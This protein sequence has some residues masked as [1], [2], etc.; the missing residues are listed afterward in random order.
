MEGGYDALPQI[1]RKKKKT[2][3]VFQVS[4]KIMECSTAW[5]VEMEQF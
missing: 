4:V 3:L 1:E 2:A 5:G